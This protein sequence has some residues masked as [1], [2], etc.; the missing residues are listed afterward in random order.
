MCFFSAV[1]ISIF[2]FTI[3]ICSIILFVIYFYYK[4]KKQKKLKSKNK[5]TNSNIMYHT[6]TK[7]ILTIQ[8]AKFLNFDALCNIDTD[9]PQKSEADVLLGE[10]SKLTSAEDVFSRYQIQ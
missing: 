8:N 5:T 9:A 7:N 2:I 1:V 6:K 10:I 3:Q 4:K